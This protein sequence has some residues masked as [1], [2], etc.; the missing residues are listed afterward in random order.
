MAR[1]RFRQRKQ[2]T[3]TEACTPSALWKPTLCLA[4]QK[5]TSRNRVGVGG[6]PSLEHWHRPS[7]GARSPH[8]VWIKITGPWNGTDPGLGSEKETPIHTVLPE[9]GTWK[10][11]CLGTQEGQDSGRASLTRS[12]SVRAPRSYLPA[13]CCR[14][15]FPATAKSLFPSL[16]GGGPCPRQV[17][18]LGRVAPAPPP[19]S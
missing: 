7:E 4:F 8:G 10:G 2:V 3:E 6:V 13:R 16:E 17:L 12:Q 1:S 9:G 19:V 14:T 11:S 5:R 18:A 15:S